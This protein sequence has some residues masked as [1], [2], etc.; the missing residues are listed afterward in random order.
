MITIPVKEKTIQ[1]P[2]K[3]AVPIRKSPITINVPGPVPYVSDKEIPWHYDGECYQQGQKLATQKSEDGKFEEE[4]SEIHDV[5]G[6]SRITRSGWIF[7]PPEQPESSADVAA[8]AKGKQIF[9]SGENWGKIL[10]F[11]FWMPRWLKM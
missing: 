3:I 8:K 11:L 4:K 5:V 1:V 7:S 10:T 9:G 2:V 6:E